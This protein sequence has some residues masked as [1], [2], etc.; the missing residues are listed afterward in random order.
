[1]FGIGF[2][3]L[4]LIAVLALIVLG[5][6]RLPGVART[7]GAMARRARSVWADVQA[8]VTRELEMQSIRDDIA[9]VATGVQATVTPLV[10]DIQSTVENVRASNTVF[11]NEAS[12]MSQ[13]WQSAATAKLAATENVMSPV[14]KDD[15]MAKEYRE[16]PTELAQALR[17]L[18][19]AADGIRNTTVDAC[20]ELRAA[21]ADVRSAAM[22][23]ESLN[24][25]ITV[26]ATIR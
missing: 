25:A 4:L 10:E 9:N 6:E 21:V 18:A 13:A 7:V 8:D 5:P 17:E 11:W 14:V 20:D 12:D 3:E 2:N 1:M 22:R 26:P 15:G 23:I 24:S 16:A 19:F